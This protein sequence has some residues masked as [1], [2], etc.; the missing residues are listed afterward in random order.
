MRHVLVIFFGLH[1]F[2]GH[3]QT[4]VL[5]IGTL[6]QSLMETSG[7][8]VYNGKLIT[9]NDSGN[10]PELYELDTLTLAITRTVRITNHSNKD[11]EDLAQDESFIYIG[12]FGNN[13]GDRQDLRVLRIAKAD[14][15]ISDEV[16]AEEIV[17]LYEDQTSFETQQDSDFDA[18]AFFSLGDDLII[19]TKQWQQQGTV[20]YKIPKLPGAFLAERLDSY[21]VDGLVT[22]A[23]FNESTNTLFLVG[24]SQFLAPF[25]VQ[26]TDV[27]STSI[28]SGIQTKTNL[29]IG[30]AQVEAIAQ[31]SEGQFYISSEQFTNPPLV[32]SLARV[33]KFPLDREVVE[34]G[35]ENPLPPG[36][37][38]EGLIVYKSFGAQQL[39]YNLNIDTPITGMGVFTN[40]GKLITYVPLEDITQTPLDISYLQ[41]SLY[42]LSFFLVGDGIISAPFFKD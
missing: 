34:E 33:F 29:N 20:A 25:F 3:S 4:E 2:L 30:F 11:W 37:F 9:H 31:D 32:N 39:N 40:S 26:V 19:L 7:L 23:T 5:E 24:Y 10:L 18:E 14:Y 12:D 8:L 1:M 28:F 21:Q 42:F 16:S 22:G 38:P 27:G 36:E 35:E 41:Q 15:D 13:N 17:F 6:P